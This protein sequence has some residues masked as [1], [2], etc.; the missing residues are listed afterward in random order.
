[1]VLVTHQVQFALQVNKIL[2]LNKEVYNDY[3]VK[4]NCHCKRLF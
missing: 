3:N 1:M 2:A 4:W